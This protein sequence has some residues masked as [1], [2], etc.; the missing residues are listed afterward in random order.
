[1]KLE[2]LGALLLWPRTMT[3]S[4]LYKCKNSKHSERKVF[5]GIGLSVY[6]LRKEMISASGLGDRIDLIEEDG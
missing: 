1:M 3:L 6:G 4:T 5:T 2:M